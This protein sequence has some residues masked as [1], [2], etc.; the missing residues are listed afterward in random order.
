MNPETLNILFYF[1]PELSLAATLIILNIINSSS[2]KKQFSNYIFT[3]GALLALVFSVSLAYYAPQQLFA[4]SFTADHFSYSGKLLISILLLFS[5]A[6]LKNKD[7][8][9]NFHSPALLQALGA[10]LTVSASNI[11]ILCA[12]IAVS[13]SPLLLTYGSKTKTALKYYI[14]SSVFFAMLLYG[15][16]LLFGLAGTGDY[17]L[18]SAYI[19]FNPF[20]HLSLLIAVLMIITGLLFTALSAPVNLNFAK[21]SGGFKHNILLNFTAINI[22]SALYAIVRFIYTVLH[23]KNTF[24]TNRAELIFQPDINWKLL[25]AVVSV[26]SVIAGNLA[27]LWQ[28]D[29]KK[30]FTFLAI[31]NSG[32]LL[33]GLLTGTNEGISSFTAGSVIFTINAAGLMF[34]I[35]LLFKYH[36]AADT[37]ALKGLGKQDKL[38]SLSLIYFLLSSAGFPLTAGFNLRILL[39]SQEGLNNYTWLIISGILSQTILLYFIYRLTIIVFSSQKSPVKPGN[40]TKIPEI[41]HKTGTTDKIILLFLLFWGIFASIFIGP[42]INWAKY[43]LIFY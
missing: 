37:S 38:V 43:C 8:E 23:D 1:L 2:G 12:A 6:A 16:T 36:G 5:A 31:S 29:L 22:L 21:I 26:C 15:G 17:N 10:M 3:G 30:I 32:L 20:N 13:A 18:I 35:Y 34:V 11:F 24:I 14:L 33:T 19:S 40:I 27:V 42:I 39:Y 7:T 25:I 41:S 28:Y 9:N 4:G